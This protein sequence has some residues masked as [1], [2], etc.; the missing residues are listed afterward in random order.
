MPLSSKSSS[1][2]SSSTLIDSKAFGVVTAILGNVWLGRLLASLLTVGNLVL[3]LWLIKTFQPVFNLVAMGLML[4]YILL[5]PVD[6]LE[7]A[8]KKFLP[9]LP[10]GHRFL[11]VT[12]VYLSLMYGLESL[13]IKGYPVLKL[14]AQDLLNSLPQQIVSANQ[15]L[16]DLTHWAP[17][18]KEPLAPVLEKLKLWTVSSDQFMVQAFQLFRSQVQWLSTWVV[19]QVGP[20][21][22]SSLGQLSTLVTLLVFVFYSLMDGERF[23]KTTVKRFPAVH[24]HLL[25]S[26]VNQLHCINMAF[27]KGQV[28]LGALTGVYMFIIYSV[29]GVKYALLLSI[30][31][32]LAELL[33]VIGTVLGLIPGLLLI[34]LQGDFIVLAYVYGCSYVFQT[35]KDNI[36]QPHVVGNALGLHPILI[37]L[38]LLLG[39]KVAGLVGVVIALPAGALFVFLLKETIAKEWTD[40]TSEASTPDAEPSTLL[41]DGGGI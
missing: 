16:I 31:F 6:V 11:A 22:Q 9:F 40:A 27:I 15:R 33:P 7:E 28:L 3:L 29:F 39:A 4:V 24:Q 20:V 18:L 26:L 1:T 17:F 2:S 5:V 37:I 12:L 32:A 19:Q 34:T 30:W 10:K 36:L 41:Q 25:F 13:V 21:L 23:V 38:S 35:I 8:F 14:Q